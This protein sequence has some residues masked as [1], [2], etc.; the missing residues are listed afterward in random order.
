MGNSI[1][2]KIKSRQS[3][4]VKP[5]IPLTRPEKNEFN[6]SQYINDTCH[7]TPGDST[8][9]KYIIKIP[10]FDSGTPE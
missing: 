5:I 6:P 8:L 7:Y 9:G 4:L 3:K 1:F 2:K 10:I